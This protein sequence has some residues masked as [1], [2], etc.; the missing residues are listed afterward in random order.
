MMG[1]ASKTID[2]G[3]GN[4]KERGA[5]GVDFN[6]STQA[7]VIADLNAYPWPFPSNAFD[8]IICRHIV[9]HV[10]DLMKFMEEVHRIARAGARVE[11]VTPHFSNR[12]S[13]TDP[14]HLRHLAWRSFDYFVER[15]HQRPNLAQRFWETKHPIPNF[16]TQARFRILERRLSFARPFRWL[17]IEKVANRF[18]DFYELYLAFTFPA[19]DLYFVLEAIK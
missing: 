7:D 10:T 17:A 13:F 16:Y 6:L 5:I 11:I 4:A 18:P 2:L 8:R 9:E 14:T 3:C 19:R 1:N 15:S 12:Y